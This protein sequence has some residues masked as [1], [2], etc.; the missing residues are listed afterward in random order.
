MHHCRIKIV[1]AAV[2]EPP[3]INIIMEPLWYRVRMLAIIHLQVV[4]VLAIN[5]TIINKLCEETRTTLT[6]AVSPI[7]SPTIT[8]NTRA[9]YH[10]IHT[11]LAATTTSITTP[12]CRL[13]TKRIRVLL[14]AVDVAV[15]AVACVVV[16]RAAVL[17]VPRMI[18]VLCRRTPATLAQLLVQV[19]AE[20]DC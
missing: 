3:L 12:A 15:T 8:N 6:R 7:T 19:T 13:Q 1:L 16:V 10:T 5:N 18:M 17:V 14:A 20:L 11:I 9:M 4:E 2:V